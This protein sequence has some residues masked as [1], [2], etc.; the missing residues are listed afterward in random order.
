MKNMCLI[1]WKIHKSIL[2]TVFLFILENSL[3][4]A[5][6]NMVAKVSNGEERVITGKVLD[7]D[8][9]AIIGAT[10]L[11]KGQKV[12]V[13][14]DINGIYK[15]TIPNNKAI[16]LVSFIGYQKQEIEVKD[17]EFITIRLQKEDQNLEEIMVV[18]YGT[19]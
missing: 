10:V 16:L 19:Q 4:I 3:C 11:I 14:T 18:A 6:G 8:G 7:S 5:S 15:I 13:I 12:G 1:R 17:K 2:F 9:E